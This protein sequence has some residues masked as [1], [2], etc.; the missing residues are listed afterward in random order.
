[1]SRRRIPFRK[2]Y[3]VLRRAV[4]AAGFNAQLQIHSSRFQ[5][6]TCNWIHP[7]YLGACI[8]V[9]RRRWGW[10]VATWN[11]RFFR[12]ADHGRIL[13]LVLEMLRGPR[14]TPYDIPAALKSKYGLIEVD[15]A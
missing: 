8:W 3:E 10:I 6:L 5:R 13:D 15:D 1:M 11:S 2:D 4:N 9:R 14:G 12:L 7:D